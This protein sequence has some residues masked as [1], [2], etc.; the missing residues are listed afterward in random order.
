MRGRRR[1]CRDW[2]CRVS[3]LIRKILAYF[4]P[5]RVCLAA[6][7]QEGS[8]YHVCSCGIWWDFSLCLQD[9]EFDAALCCELQQKQHLYQ[10]HWPVN[11]GCSLCPLKRFA[12]FLNLL[13]L[14]R[15]LFE[16][17]LLQQDFQ[18]CYSSIPLTWNKQK[19]KTMERKHG[20][21]I[22]CRDLIYL[23]C[24]LWSSFSRYT[25]LHVTVS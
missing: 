12:S 15:C 6:H 19:I 5:L 14:V 8:C 24:Y 10:V 11:Q 20:N 13:L 16:T 25:C 1:Q 22:C 3:L 21:L 17:N 7:E 4:S 23:F 9:T 2:E 18:F